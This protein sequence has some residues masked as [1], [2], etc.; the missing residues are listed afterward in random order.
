MDVHITAHVG[1]R[2]VR[3]ITQNW[4]TCKD[5]KPFDW[6]PNYQ[7]DFQIK[8]H[9][10][11]GINHDGCGL[12]PYCRTLKYSLSRNTNSTN[13]TILADSCEFCEEIIEVG[14]GLASLAGI[15]REETIIRSLEGNNVFTVETG[16]LDINNFHLKHMDGVNG[17]SNCFLVMSG[18]GKTTVKKCD[19]SCV[20]EQN[21]VHSSV[22]KVNAGYALL[23]EV[24]MFE[25]RFSSCCAISF[26]QEAET[27]VLEIIS[28][29]SSKLT[30]ANGGGSIA[31]GTLSSGGKIIVSNCLMK[32][33]VCED[34]NGGAL[35]INVEDEGKIEVNGTECTK[36]SKCRARNAQNGQTRQSGYGGGIYVYFSDSSHS[37]SLTNV[38]FEECNAQMGSDIFINGNVLKEIV[39]KNTFNFVLD[40]NNLSALCGIDRSA[41]LEHIIPL[42]CFLRQWNG[43][44]H[45]N[46]SEGTDFSGCGFDDCPCQTIEAAVALRFPD[47]KR[48]VMLGTG[49]VLDHEMHLEDHEYAIGDENLPVS[50][51]V[52]GMSQK[53]SDEL[54]L[55]SISTSICGIFFVLPSS[56]NQR[57]SLIRSSFDL[58]NLSAL[59][60]RK[61]SFLLS[62]QE[63]ISCELTYSLLSAT[64]GNLII[65]RVSASKLIFGR[66]SAFTASSS[67]MNITEM[68]L[69]YTQTTSTCGLISLAKENLISSVNS[70]SNSFSNKMLKSTDILVNNSNFISC[71]AQNSL[72]GGC[73]FIEYCE[74]M[75][76]EIKDSI[77]MLCKAPR[78]KGDIFVCCTSLETQIS[79][80]QFR[81]HVEEP[82]YNTKNAIFGSNIHRGSDEEDVNIIDLIMGYRNDL[83]FIGNELH[84]GTILKN[85]GRATVPCLTLNHG[86]ERL[87]QSFESRIVVNGSSTISSECNLQDLSI[88]SISKAI[89]SLLVNSD[90]N[91]TRDSL[92]CCAGN[93]GI[94]YQSFFFGIS[95]CSLHQTFF[96][97]NSGEVKF[98]RC[99]FKLSEADSVRNSQQDSMASIPFTLLLI[100]SSDAILQSCELED[101]S[102]KNTC[103]ICKNSA[104]LQIQ[105]F[106]CRRVVLHS[107]L[108]IDTASAELSHICLDAVTCMN[109]IFVFEEP[110]KNSSLEWIDARNITLKKGSVF[111]VN[112]TVQTE[113]KQPFVR[114]NM[115]FS[116]F[117]NITSSD[118]SS[119]I[120][121]FA[122]QIC[123][124]H[125]LNCS[126]SLCSSSGDRGQLASFS[127]LPK[128]KLESC[129][130]DGA[131]N[132]EN[133]VCLHERNHADIFDNNASAHSENVISLNPQRS[134]ISSSTVS[135][136]CSWNSSI[137]D[138][139]C[140][141]VE[142]V[143]SSFVNAPSGALSASGG[144]IRLKNVEF[145][146]NSPSIP[147]FESARRNILCEDAAQIDAE[148]L[149]KGDEAASSSSLWILN[150]GCNL[151]GIPSILTS[152]FFIPSLHSIRSQQSENEIELFFAGSLLLP[153]NLSLQ[154]IIS[155]GNEEHIETYNF[156]IDDYVSENEIHS[157][158]P[159]SDFAS[160][161]GNTEISACILFG[162]T[163]SPSST[164]SFILKNASETKQKDDER[165]V[166]GGK[167][168]KSSWALIVIVLLIVILLIVLIVAIAFIVRWRK[169]K[170]RTE[171]LEI[172]VEDNVKKDPKAF[173][174]ATM[175]MSLE[176]QWMRAEK[177]AEKKN[178]ERIKKRVYEKSLGHSESSEHLLSES[179]STEYILGRDSD[180]I[181]Q[182]MLEKVDE[183]EE[184]ETR[185][186]ALSPSIS[187]TSTTSTTDSD[188]TFVRS[189]SL[190]P[191]TSSMSNLVDAMA[192]SS[193]HEKL[194]V[195]LRDSLFM[196]LHGRNEKKE[197]AIGTLKER[198]QTAAQILFW[199]ANLALHSF[200]EMENSLQSLANLSPH[201]V[202]FSEHMVICIVMHSDFLS[203]DDSD[204]SS[205]S[206]S[207]VVT[208]ASDDDDDS[209]PSS[210]FEDEDDF[211]KECMR[212]KAPE[213]L[214]NKKMGATKESVAFSIG[215]MLW[216]CLTLKIPFG[217]YEAEIAGQKIVNGE[218][219]KMEIISESRMKGM[220][221]KAMSMNAEHRHSLAQIKREFVELFPQSAMV[222]T[223]T[224][225]INLENRE[226][227]IH[228]AAIT[229][230]R[231]VI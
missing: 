27:C 126:C 215:M 151:S 9:F 31:E 103:F 183:K 154:I 5:S 18:N 101:S 197:M 12:A 7:T 37:I 217:E 142:D 93:V 149:K 43:A 188:S 80:K 67:T 15:S 198:E 136:I 69:N 129:T 173:E 123:E 211:K 167:E 99:S 81:F 24:R 98:T 90:I 153:C 219:P 94:E 106:S 42:V 130:F 45:V 14:T 6:L 108:V 131:S 33:S 62:A 39:R 72:K 176:E 152:P 200:D 104:K 221:E 181:P 207:T 16:T 57:S 83:I 121:S 132:K 171:E 97:L 38:S 86:L 22:F 30:R 41:S 74:G 134:K 144:D 19:V 222:F 141:S 120:F 185:K 71:E 21:E 158:I 70:S 46:G 228:S 40:L 143:N 116:S 56:L 218:R 231:I 96:F 55:V 59:S 111:S 150:N 82:A 196:L 169:Q 205:I 223:M 147:F 68:T 172:I 220:V 170:R 229:N 195:D 201:I 3:C 49:F 157:S 209:L 194:I 112:N 164:Q 156:G 182:W 137:V 210:A 202:L 11:E 225:A 36:F 102:C 10:S 110:K 20:D 44:A 76:L 161:T 213:L 61:C 48:M 32:E 105:D 13:T 107:P 135:E 189:E 177:E 145:R 115:S 73:V 29:N 203:D 128:L 117:R 186:R 214:I 204:S 65:D 193:P 91:C 118:S 100:D 47:Q 64:G 192:C 60:L 140:C 1:T 163:E 53:Q 79:E 58:S 66:C 162:N 35:S 165:L 166:E 206:S 212:W 17:T 155:S 54:L 63:E 114:I 25:V 199:V 146:N 224:D 113:Q 95:F 174:M 175:E 139:T 208:S 179:G 226:S 125:L 52:N 50:I 119:T 184:E 92:M 230:N 122:S 4:Y 26:E 78:G 2:V 124:V 51:S 87:T 138:I 133:E 190:C 23:E 75:K 28:T 216:E 88:R 127:S 191:T 77:F 168:G 159:S 178:D 85:C 148:S 34:G 180:K 227:D 84:G 8:A 187:S 109:S 89:T 160:T